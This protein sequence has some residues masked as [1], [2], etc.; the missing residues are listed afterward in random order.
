MFAPCACRVLFIALLLCGMPA[1]RAAAA[2]PDA[3]E[4][5][6]ITQ[7]NAFRRSQGLGT[8]Q[9]QPQLQAAAAGFA[10][11]MA[12][13]DRYGHQADGRAPAQRV[14]A[15]GYEYC[16][17]D[18]NIAFEYRSVPFEPGELPGRFVRGWIHS[19]GH[20]AN[21][22]DAAAVDTGVGIAQ[23]PRSGRW[24]AVQVFGRPQSRSVEF[25]VSN[26]SGL[27]AAYRLDGRRYELPPRSTMTHR[28]CT[29]PLLQLLP[30]REGDTGRRTAD[31]QRYELFSA[32]GGGWRLR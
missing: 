25:Q 23:S 26:T 8:L 27:T 6:V 30:E 22:L 10:A 31:G 18:E 15:E 7:A 11:Y 4:R 24:Y 28:E 17:V 29:A 9:L 19:P 32:P 21:L 2:E 1:A 3:N 5:A 14:E 16:L 20:R 13:T 12:R